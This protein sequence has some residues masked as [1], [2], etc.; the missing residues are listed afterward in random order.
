M[1]DI[2]IKIKKLKS[3]YGVPYYRSHLDE[4]L[5]LDEYLKYNGYC[6]AEANVYRKIIAIPNFKMK[7]ELN[8]M[9][10]DLQQFYKSDGK[11]SAFRRRNLK[12]Y[13]N[14]KW[15]KCI[16][17][18]LDKMLPLNY[19]ETNYAKYNEILTDL[20]NIYISKVT[21]F[22]NSGNELIKLVDNIM[23]KK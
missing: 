1:N 23:N 20:E 8:K 22:Y 19:K 12:N 5:T 18:S 10:Y 15:H 11:F 13:K 16:V 21:K 17:N 4:M 3:L 14:W 6:D 2:E 7:Y 9:F